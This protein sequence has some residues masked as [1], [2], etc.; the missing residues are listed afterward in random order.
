M[1]DDNLDRAIELSRNG[2]KAEAREILKV[3]L[4]SNPH[5][6]TAWLWFADTFPD[7]H[8]RILALEECLKHNPNSQAAQKFLV[9]F[10]SEEAKTATPIQSQNKGAQKPKDKK[11]AKRNTPII[12]LISAF[13]TTIILGL[14]IF[15]LWILQM[16]VIITIPGVKN[17][18]ALNS[19]QTNTLIPTLSFTS[20][21]TLTQ[22]NTSTPTFTSTT[23][24]TPTITPSET[25]IDTSTP[26][27]SPTPSPINTQTQRPTIPIQNTPK[28]TS[29]VIISTP[30]NQ[31]PTAIPTK[32]RTSTKQPTS[33]VSCG[34]S[35]SL[36]SATYRTTIS[37][38][39]NFSP[40]QSGLGFTV[41][42]FNPQYSG[43]RGCSA[44]DGNIDGYASCDGNS[45]MLPYGKTVTVTFSTSVGKCYATYRSQ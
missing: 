16:Q 41:D 7:T 24:N 28:P 1:P 34:V 12:F 14:V 35:P 3:I 20:T 5:D 8:N 4:R 9:T 6:E 22:T 13:G 32:Q 37:F 2:K 15:S 11:I 40:P 42:V 25:P 31:Q 33:S 30:T 23:T 44:V 18:I 19:T 36:V 27:T 38:Y 21:N 26:E 45:G 43:Q 17:L 39:V 29:I 10:K